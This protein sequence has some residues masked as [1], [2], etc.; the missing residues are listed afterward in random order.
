MS[1]STRV[2]TTLPAGMAGMVD[3]LEAVRRAKM[4][5]S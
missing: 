3:A 4:V 5:T 1:G 2:A